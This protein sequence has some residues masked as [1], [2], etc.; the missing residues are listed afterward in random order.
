MHRG[1]EKMNGGIV[2]R[3]SKVRITEVGARHTIYLR[4]DFVT[5]STFPFKPGQTL[6]AKIVGKRVIIEG[7]D[8]GGR[9]EKTGRDKT[10]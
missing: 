1:M 6:V 9:E 2:V 5:D 4:K 3:E 10:P 7:P 8:G